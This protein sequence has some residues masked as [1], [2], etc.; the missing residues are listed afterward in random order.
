MH[1]ANKEYEAKEASLVN[2]RDDPDV[3]KRRTSGGD[4]LEPPCYVSYSKKHKYACLHKVHGCARRP[5]WEIKD[6]TWVYG[7]ES[8][9]VDQ[10]CR[11][12]WKE[13]GRP[14]TVKE[15]EPDAGGPVKKEKDER[16]DEAVGSGVESGGD[17][18][19]SSTNPS[20]ASADCDESGAMKEATD[21]RRSGKAARA[22]SSSSSSSSYSSKEDSRSAGSPGSERPDYGSQEHQGRRSP[23]N[24]RKRRRQGEGRRSASRS[25]ASRSETA[26]AEA[27]AGEEEPQDMEVDDE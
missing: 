25:D 16:E 12:C 5:H 27:A 2:A 21:S 19:D 23:R 7:D 22:T 18:S 3:G 13:G 6:F 17:D 8:L 9:Q 20:L 24:K 14:G 11:D 1:M 15:E 4:V 10:L 26:G